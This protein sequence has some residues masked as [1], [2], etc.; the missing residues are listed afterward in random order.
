MNLNALPR[1]ASASPVATSPYL[2]VE[3]YDDI[4][5]LDAQMGVANKRDIPQQAEAALFGGNDSALVALLDAAAIPSLKERLK[6]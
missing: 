4:V 5:S 1:L 6:H 3:D 2:A